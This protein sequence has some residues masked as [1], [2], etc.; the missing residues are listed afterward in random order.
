V[1]MRIVQRGAVVGLIM[2]VRVGERVC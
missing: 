1:R 2:F